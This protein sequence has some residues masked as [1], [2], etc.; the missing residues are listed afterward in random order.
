MLHLSSKAYAACAGSV[1]YMCAAVANRQRRRRRGGRGM[2]KRRSCGASASST[3]LTG[4]SRRTPTPA[5][6]LQASRCLPS[7]PQ[8]PFSLFLISG[9]CPPR[10]TYVVSKGLTCTCD[11]QGLTR[12]WRFGVK[13][14]AEVVC[15]DG[16]VRHLCACKRAGIWLKL[17]L[18]YE[19]I[20]CQ[21]CHGRLSDAQ[22]N[23][24]A[25]R[26]VC[27]L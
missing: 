20:N 2:R 27:G 24:C 6:T 18:C 3:T 1:K 21:R 13:R 5:P 25:G 16:A 9:R 7:S 12:S 22:N 19:G 14:T 15:T 10:Q 26:A 8:E 17:I 11:L 4:F 23:M